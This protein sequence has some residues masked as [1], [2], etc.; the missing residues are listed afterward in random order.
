MKRI[1]NLINPKT[2]DI[3]KHSVHTLVFRSLK[4]T[5]DMFLSDYSHPIEIDEKSKEL[6]KT[7]KAKSDF[8]QVL[9][10]PRDQPPVRSKTQTKSPDD[11][12]GIDVDDHIQID[13]GE[14]GVELAETRRPPIQSKS[15]IFAKSGT[16]EAT[17]TSTSNQQLALFNTQSN[18]LVAQKKNSLLMPKP[19]WHPPWKLYR[20]ISGHLGWVRC[21]D[22]D[23]SNEWFVTGST[24]RIIKV[25]RVL[26][27]IG[28]RDVT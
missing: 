16:A 7:V 25:R 1:G 11:Q 27:S 21:I 28:R 2:Q 18:S 4:R 12:S 6:R 3:P 15:P 23:P 20:V 13:E 9:S 17:V 19:Q 5:A 14:E 8:G 22:I 26:V 10:M 24:D